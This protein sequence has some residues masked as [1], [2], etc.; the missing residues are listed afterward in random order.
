MNGFNIIFLIAFITSSSLVFGVPEHDSNTIK[1]IIDEWT[2]K[3]KE[4]PQKFSRDQ[5][6]ELIAR[7]IIDKI[8]D[9]QF[10]MKALMNYA[11]FGGGGAPFT[12]RMVW[13][14]MASAEVRASFLNNALQTATNESIGYL[15]TFTADDLVDL[16]TA[17]ANPG[18][19]GATALEREIVFSGKSFMP[20]FHSSEGVGSRLLAIWFSKAP[21]LAALASL[22]PSDGEKREQIRR[23]NGL[24]HEIDKGRSDDEK[25]LAWSKLDQELQSLF[26]SE[27]PVFEMYAAGVL[28]WRRMVEPSFTN[29]ESLADLLAKCDNPIVTCIL[30]GI[31]T[32]TLTSLPSD[33]V[34]LVSTP[35]PIVA[36][37]AITAQPTPLLPMATPPPQEQV[38]SSSPPTMEETKPAP[39]PWIIGAILL[40]AVFGGVWWK[41]LRK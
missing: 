18:L 31:T 14:K 19:E 3:I 16:E 15:S 20:L 17:L 33:K 23:I 2:I 25:K 6:P 29:S 39:W 24:R 1:S 22:H 36:P 10:R 40:L 7:S 8:P 30:Q 37:T 4:S 13:K 5:M 35:N 41:C 28:K 38:A 9:T 11:A 34:I 12:A 21:Y 27:S 26:L 32:E